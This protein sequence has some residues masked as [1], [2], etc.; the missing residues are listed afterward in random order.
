M[1]VLAVA[2]SSQDLA[3]DALYHFIINSHGWLKTVL[4]RLQLTAALINFS[5][6]CAELNRGHN[7]VLGKLVLK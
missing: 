5:A 2:E 4:H 7:I 1:S 3:Q 6:P